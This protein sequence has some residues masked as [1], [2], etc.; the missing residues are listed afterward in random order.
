ML[1]QNR[2]VASVVIRVQV[3]ENIITRVNDAIINESLNASNIL[4]N[5]SND[6]DVKI[7]TTVPISKLINNYDVNILQII[8]NNGLNN[9][10]F[11]FSNMFSY[12]KNNLIDL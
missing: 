4:L 10:V 8:N 11:Q 9:Y 7:S 5:N 3:V 1:I 6:S 2:Q 12:G